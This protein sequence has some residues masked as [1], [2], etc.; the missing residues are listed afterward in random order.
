MYRFVCVLNNQSQ[1]TNHLCVQMTVIIQ[2]YSS[3]RQSPWHY[4][5]SQGKHI[6]AF[7]FLRHL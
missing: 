1:I 3:F 7:L 5:G 4:Y 6:Q 2:A